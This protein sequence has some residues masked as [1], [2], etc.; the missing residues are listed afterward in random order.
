MNRLLLLCGCLFL[1]FTACKKAEDP[2]VFNSNQSAIDDKLI[3]DY[4]AAN[5][6]TGKAV[7]VKLGTSSSP[8]TT[9]IWYV[10]EKQ[11]PTVAQYSLSS[12][13]TVSYVAKVLTTGE[14]IARTDNF[15]PAYR[16]GE[17]IRGWQLAIPNA[18]PNKGSTIRLLVASRYAYGPYAQPNLGAKGLP[19]NSVL[20]FTIDIF[21]VTN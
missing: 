20:D 8:D 12:Y 9:G 14:V 7:K 17:T 2:A 6:L 1:L 16:L 15:Q 5:G 11:G 4:I 10:I 21:D 13:I 19:A 18:R 3:S